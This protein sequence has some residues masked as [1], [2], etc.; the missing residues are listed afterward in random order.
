VTSAKRLVIERVLGLATPTA[1]EDFL[2][3]PRSITSDL[4][5]VDRRLRI[6]GRLT[7]PARMTIVRLQRGGLFLHSP[8]QLDAATRSAVEALGPVECIVAP[9]TFHH[10]FVNDCASAF[11]AAHV[12]LAPGLAERRPE[13]RRGLTLDETAP[14]AWQ[15]EIEQ[16]VFGPV[17]RVSEVVFYHRR[18]RTVLLTDLALNMRSA[19]TLSER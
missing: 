12:Y 10:L 15:A 6:R 14:P 9:N 3:P 16:L 1:V 8:C 5:V 17:R 2:P 18:S 4:W 7:I 13:V 11:P 19:A